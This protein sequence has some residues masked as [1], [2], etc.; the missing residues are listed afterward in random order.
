[1]NGNGIKGLCIVALLVLLAMIIFGCTQPGTSS[2]ANA[3]GA[4]S[5]SLTSSDLA[6]LDSVT[7][8]LNDAMNITT[9]TESVGSTNQT[10]ADATDVATQA[11]S[12]A[13]SDTNATV[14]QKISGTS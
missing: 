10:V 8:Q 14:K 1:M 13:V 11:A 6:E 7:Q 3:A 12:K 5:G 2:D 9:G 4:S